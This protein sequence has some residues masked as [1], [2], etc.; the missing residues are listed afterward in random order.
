LLYRVHGY[1]LMQVGDLFGAEESLQRS[2]ESAR[3]RDADYDVALTLHALAQLAALRD[4][5]ADA[6]ATESTSLF[7]ELGILVVPELPISSLEP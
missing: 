3:G 5:P 7:A 2:L 1:A 4:E 6:Y